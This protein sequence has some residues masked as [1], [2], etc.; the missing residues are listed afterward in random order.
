MGLAETRRSTLP[1]VS[2][3]P[4]TSPEDGRGIPDYKPLKRQ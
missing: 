4:A 1:N 2:V 3:P